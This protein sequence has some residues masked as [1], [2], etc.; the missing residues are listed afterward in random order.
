MRGWKVALDS[1]ADQPGATSCGHENTLLSFGTQFLHF[2]NHEQQ[3]QLFSNNQILL[4]GK[5][6]VVLRELS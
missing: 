6:L 4:G 3:G 2:I 1:L 5:S